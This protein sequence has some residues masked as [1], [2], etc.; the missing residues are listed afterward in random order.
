MK[1]NIK[2]QTVYLD[3]S[4]FAGKVLLNDAEDKKCALLIKKISDKEC[5][6]Y[7]FITS[8]FTLV[9]LA[10]LIS[11]RETEDKAK[12]ILFDIMNDPDLPIYLINPEPVHKASKTREYFDIDILIAHLVKTALK[13]SI[14]GF[15][16][17]HAHTVRNLDE[18]I[19]A[20]SKDTHFK[21]FNK[22]EN[23]IDVVNASDFLDKYK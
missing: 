11:R 4:I 13:Y 3:T 10:E 17:I 7:K 21:R 12:S 22:L 18:K 19:I 23:V 20:V 14:P 6:N 5:G 8:I 2:S 1:D 15:D 16:T 9:E